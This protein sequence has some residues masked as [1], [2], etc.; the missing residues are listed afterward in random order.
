MASQS[1]LFLAFILAAVSGCSKDPWPPEERTAEVRLPEMG[2][3]GDYPP[4]AGRI[5]INADDQGCFTVGG[6]VL[7]WDQLIATI[8]SRVK[9]APREDHPDLPGSALSRLDVVLRFDRRLP[10]AVPMKLISRL[11]SPNLIASRIYFSVRH[12]KDHSEGAVA[13][14]PP[15]GI[16]VSGAMLVLSIGQSQKYSLSIEGVYSVLIGPS[17]DKGRWYFLVEADPMAS[18]ADVLRGVDVLLRAGANKIALGSD[19]KAPRSLWDSAASELVKQVLPATRL[20]YSFR[21]IRDNRKLHFPM[22][23]DLACPPIPACPPRVN[24]IAGVSAYI[25]GFPVEEEEPGG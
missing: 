5:L 20:H 8:A 19:R 23:H 7:D 12:E 11:C 21:L 24:G 9:E 6:E 14:F 1:I 2:T 3:V 25:S 4:A 13:C 15:G 17:V 10:F 18:L 16:T 22:P